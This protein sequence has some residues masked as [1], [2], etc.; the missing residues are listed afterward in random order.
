MSS[1]RTDPIRFCRRDI[2]QFN[3]YQLSNRVI[4]FFV[5]RPGEQ[6][7][8]AQNNSLFCITLNLFNRSYNKVVCHD[9]I[10]RQQKDSVPNTVR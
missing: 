3:V 5:T 9:T 10:F 1:D 8:L 4:W 7:A 2:V 6:S